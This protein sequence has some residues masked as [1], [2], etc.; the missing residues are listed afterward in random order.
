MRNIFWLLLLTLSLIS[1]C[2]ATNE[3]S[4]PPAHRVLMPG[5]T[6]KLQDTLTIP[7]HQARVYIQFGEVIQKLE[8][9]QYRPSCN[10]LSFDVLDSE[11]SIAPD[12]FVIARIRNNSEL[13][14][15]SRYM[16]ASLMNA[17]LIDLHNNISPMAEVFTV[18]L[19]IESKINPRIMRLECEA[20]RKPNSF[21]FLTL[22]DIQ[23]TLGDIIVLDTS[24]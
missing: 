15:S 19:D 12:Q 20:W 2:S 7:P 14:Q 17:S 9:D 10:L 5:M 1:A 24:N 3:K 22:A 16:L 23:R 21:D 6:L 4:E 13:L 8:V 11:Q 18:L